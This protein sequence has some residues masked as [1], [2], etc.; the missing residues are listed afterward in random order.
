MQRSR[1]NIRQ[2]SE[3]SFQTA[4]KKRLPTSNQSAKRN[5]ALSNQREKRYHQ[6]S[7]QREKRYHQLSNQKAKRHHQLSNQTRGNSNGGAV[8]GLVCSLST[9]VSGVS[10]V[11]SPVYR[12]RMVRKQPQGGRLGVVRTYGKYGTRTVNGP[13]WLSPEVGLK[14]LFSSS[15][16][17]NASS[18]LS[19]KT[20][21]SDESFVVGRKRLR[22]GVLRSFS[23]GKVLRKNVKKQQNTESQKGKSYLLR[24]RRVLR[25]KDRSTTSIE[26][27]SQE[28][29]IF[30]EEKENHFPHV[31]RH[32]EQIPTMAQ[33]KFVTYRRKLRKHKIASNQVRS[34]QFQMREKGFIRRSGQSTESSV[35]FDKMKVSNP[36]FIKK[37]NRLPLQ[38]STPSCTRKMKIKKP[39]R[40]LISV[41]SENEEDYAWKNSVEPCTAETTDL[42]SVVEICCFRQSN[43]SC[44][45]LASTEFSHYSEF[46]RQS[47]RKLE[48]TCGFE[49]D[50]KP[51]ASVE[52]FEY[53]DLV[54]SRPFQVQNDGRQQTSYSSFYSKELFSDD[55]EEFQVSPK[56]GLIHETNDLKVLV[57]DPS[58]KSGLLNCALNLNLVNKQ[59]HREC[60]NRDSNLNF[61]PVV[62]LDHFSV[63][64]YL[65]NQR[66]LTTEH[67][68]SKASSFQGDAEKKQ[69]II[70]NLHVKFT[71]QKCLVK[72]SNSL[73][74]KP[75]VLL[76][77]L[78]LQQHL[79]QKRSSRNSLCLSDVDFD[80]YK[81]CFEM[82]GKEHYV[83]SYPS[84]VHLNLQMDQLGGESVVQDKFSKG[85]V[86]DT[87]ALQ[88][89]GGQNDKTLSKE[90]HC[91]MKTRSLSRQNNLMSN[92]NVLGEQNTLSKSIHQKR[93]SP[94]SATVKRQEKS[95]LDALKPTFLPA[96]EKKN[97]QSSFMNSS[98]STPL[99]SRNWSRFKAAHSLHKKKQVITPVKLNE[100][101]L[102]FACASQR[103]Q[104]NNQSN[105]IAPQGTLVSMENLSPTPI[106]SSMKRSK[107]FESSEVEKL[108]SA[109]LLSVIQSDEEKVYNEC[110]QNGPIS[111]KECIPL[112]KLRKC[113][114]VGEGVFGEVFQTINNGSDVVFKII[115]IEGKKNVNGEPQKRFAE[116]LPEIIISKKL[117]QLN[118]G[119]ENST[120]GFIS[121]YSVHCIKDSYPPELLKAWDKYNQIKTSENDRPDE[122]QNDQL[123]IIFEFEYGGCDLESMRTKIPSLEEARSILHQV[124]ASLAVAE[125]TLN[126][127]HRDLHWGNV[128]IR[129]T[130]TK[131]VE[132]KLCGKTFNVNTHGYV[133]HIIDYTLSRMGKDVVYFCDL[134]AD[135]SF[136]HG[137]GDYQFDI[138]RKMKEENLN[139]WADYNPH[140]NV[141]WLH[142]LADKMLN[143]R[144]KRTASKAL[145]MLK[146][147]FQEFMKESLEYQSAV[148]LLQSSQLFQQN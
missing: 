82:L 110:H 25:N 28:D 76:R 127:E 94:I 58:A 96:T 42:P 116:I 4:F 43:S 134:S 7:N 126:F 138:Y 48:G 44:K 68:F 23:K 10:D 93:S 132:Y 119:S 148:D 33:S 38:T 130:S 18:S 112:S 139:N 21:T 147:M 109:L 99:G 9:H 15:E 84:A 61:Q 29:S 69:Q 67:G 135:D 73:V 114:K 121:L 19:P 1:R 65:H 36:S 137:Q 80:E 32:K 106:C 125:T 105:L 60:G 81:Y 141:L 91:Q 89:I 31:T 104:S 70:N 57:K 63:E 123:Y 131:E 13:K 17:A 39:S 95:T 3:F 2:E 118:K 75:I 34:T 35:C 78:E 100:S 47:H 85:S 45:E 46:L 11:Y 124:T 133:A 37:L 53:V 30:V 144:Y 16:S 14:H 145:K 86:I 90:N 87:N 50:H 102:E 143:M 115:P 54:T 129:K 74:W 120:V 103:A 59:E 92:F 77:R 122:L 72:S 128:L 117:S 98:V 6:L 24:K 107:L 88:N 26:G 22:G 79:S 140:T 136:F 8:N 55:P 62:K 101:S 64:N 40:C 66:S 49:T 27:E 146:G 56:A 20:D 5:H 142:Y 111:F 12:S 83:N 108:S 52:D 41:D 113:E 97:L 51:V 71:P